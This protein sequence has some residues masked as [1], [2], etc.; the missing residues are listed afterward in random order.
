MQANGAEAE[1]PALGVVST[2]EAAKIRTEE[3]AKA[4]AA[5][6]AAAIAGAADAAQAAKGLATTSPSNGAEFTPAFA[7]YFSPEA[8]KA[9]N[10]YKESIK[11]KAAP[12][13]IS[14]ADNILPAGTKAY[15]DTFW[16]YGN[17]VLSIIFVFAEPVLLVFLYDY[18]NQ[19]SLWTISSG[20]IQFALAIYSILMTF[21]STEV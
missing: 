9:I 1:S 3:K 16:Y 18:F 8:I 2:A 4:D 19:W 17:I 12:S 6:A 21:G 7:S 13:D 5:A 20:I 11:P 14:D 15:G 10:D